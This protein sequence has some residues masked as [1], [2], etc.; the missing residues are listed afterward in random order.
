VPV[1]TDVCRP[2]PWPDT[3]TTFEF[4][5]PPEG[6]KNV[7][8][9]TARLLASEMPIVI[10]DHLPGELADFIAIDHQTPMPAVRLV[11]CKAS[12]GAQP[13]ARVT[14]LE[15]L[16]AQAIR[17]VQ[18]LTPRADL[19]AELRKRLDQR[20][21]TKIVEGERDEIVSLLDEWSAKPP[22]ASWSLW[23]VQP[24]LSAAALSTSPQT[25]SLI[26]TAHSWVTSQNVEFGLICSA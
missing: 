12:G 14:D 7:G 5:E 15:E 26:N 8:G 20:P 3:A 25:T 13:A 2:R 22:L 17:S 19:W 10:Q 6:L 16:V 9:A 1:A 4:R 24:G 11:H 21:A 23:L 18:W